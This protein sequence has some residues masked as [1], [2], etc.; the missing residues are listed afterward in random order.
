MEQQFNAWQGCKDFTVSD[1]PLSNAEAHMVLKSA[2]DAAAQRANA[3]GS[4][5][6]PLQAAEQVAEAFLAARRVLISAAAP[7][8]PAPAVGVPGSEA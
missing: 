8:A 4:A 7:G 3:L 1:A 6:T 5:L 2:T